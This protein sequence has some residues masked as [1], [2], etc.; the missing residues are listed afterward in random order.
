MWDYHDHK[1]KTVWRSQEQKRNLSNKAVDYQH[2]SV[3]D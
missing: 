1:F 2:A 3:F